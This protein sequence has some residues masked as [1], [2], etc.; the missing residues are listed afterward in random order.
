MKRI[1]CLLLGICFLLSACTRRDPASDVLKPDPQAT[2][3]DGFYDAQTVLSGGTPMTGMNLRK[4]NVSRTA[5]G[6]TDVEILFVDGSDLMDIPEAD[7][8]DVPEYSTDWYEGAD[9]FILRLNGVLYWDYLLDL[10]DTQGTDLQG[11]FS[12]RSDEAEGSLFILHLSRTMDYSLKAEK[13][14]LMLRFRPVEEEQD[15]YSFL[16]IG[17]YEDYY[18][19]VSAELGELGFAPSLCA[20]GSS[21]VLLSVPFADEKQ[22]ELYLQGNESRISSLLPGLT[23]SVQTFPSNRLPE[24]TKESGLDH[25]AQTVMALKSGEP[26]S[27]IMIERG[28]FLCHL[29][30]GSGYLYTKDLVRRTEEEELYQELRIHTEERDEPVLDQFEFLSVSS[31]QCSADG[32]YAALTEQTLFRQELSVVSLGNGEVYSPMED[33][34]EGSVSYFV[35]DAGKPVLYAFLRTE[36]TLS[37]MAY[38][39]TEPEHPAVSTIASDFWEESPLYFVDGQVW[40]IQRDDSGMQRV[41]AVQPGKGTRTYR[42]EAYALTMSPDGKTCASLRNDGEGNTVLTFS[43]AAT[44]RFESQTEGIEWIDMAWDASGEYLYGTAL[45]DDAGWDDEYPL[46]LFRIDPRDGSVTSWMKV[47]T[48]ALYTGAESGEVWMIYIFTVRDQP[49]TM[50]YKL[51]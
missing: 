34:M 25:L 49:V 26:A 11:M 23:A 7:T 27:E 9:R 20:D 46:N 42:E 30:D 41:C 37:L 16:Y 43:A 14:R 3:S 32:R 15:N 35:W 18:P 13:N 33:G 1:I 44:G 4:V 36:E 47:R 45:G 50:T 28:G 21:T 8:P 10:P 17:G 5:E 2:P 12:I 19:R 31:A 38:D 29:P 22:A 24:Y 51:S 6:E 40:T 39:L 48:G